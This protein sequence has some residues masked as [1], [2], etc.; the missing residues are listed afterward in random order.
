MLVW[1]MSAPRLAM[2]LSAPPQRHRGRPVRVLRPTNDP[3]G[4]LSHLQLGEPLCFMVAQ[5]LIQASHCIASVQLQ[6][7]RNLVSCT[8]LLIPGGTR[9]E[10]PDGVE[11]SGNAQEQFFLITW[12][13]DSMALSIAGLTVMSQSFRPNAEVRGRATIYISSK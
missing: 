6:F 10:R 11:Q 5:H 7:V 3:L 1:T 9:W 2:V 12:H 8:P 4:L 13:N